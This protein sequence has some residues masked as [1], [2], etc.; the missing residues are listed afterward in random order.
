MTGNAPLEGG[1]EEPPQGSGG[2]TPGDARDDLQAIARTARAHLPDDFTVGTSMVRTAGGEK[3]QVTVGFPTGETL[4]AQ[5]DL[6][7][8]PTADPEEPIDTDALAAL[9]TEL[10]ASV[11]YQWRRMAEPGADADPVAR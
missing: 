8:V 11:L 3:A 7:T 4:A 1:P 2:R 9:G 5:L 10:V 6:G